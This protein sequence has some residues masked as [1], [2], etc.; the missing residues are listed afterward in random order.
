MSPQEDQEGR[1]RQQLHGHS[2]ESLASTSSRKSSNG[3]DSAS[4]RT[5]GVE[6]FR[7]S[8]L[9]GFQGTFLEMDLTAMKEVVTK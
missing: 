8:G 1:R 6:K 4:R 2:R 5:S 9:V 7:P 3:R